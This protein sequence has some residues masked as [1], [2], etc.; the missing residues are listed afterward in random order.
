MVVCHHKG[1]HQDGE[2]A[3]RDSRKLNK[4]EFQTWHPEMNNPMHLH[5]L[6]ANQQESSLTGNGLGILMDT[7]LTVSLQCA[8]VAKK[9]KSYP[10]CIR[11]NITT[12]QERWPSL[13]P[14][15]QWDTSGWCGQCWALGYKRDVN[16][17][18]RVHRRTT[19]MMKG[20]QLQQWI[21]DFLHPRRAGLGGNLSMCINTW[22][23]G[24]DIGARLL[25]FVCS[26]R[27]AGHGQKLK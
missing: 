3:D 22:W 2:M 20:L 19:K 9:T 1:P 26:D 14:Q 7:K 24:K 21:W 15:H 10:G 13:C 6:G 16:M 11:Q 4:W 8:L 12:G 17:M 27:T 23:E 25:S 18:G 5:M